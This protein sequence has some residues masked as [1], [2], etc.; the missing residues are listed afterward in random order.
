MSR[1]YSGFVNGQVSDWSLDTSQD[2]SICGWLYIVS[3]SSGG[4]DVFFTVEGS[5]NVSAYQVYIGYGRRSPDTGFAL[6]FRCGDGAET[7][8]L[9]VDAET[10][11][12]YHL[13]LCK[14]SGQVTAYVD[15]VQVAQQPIV[16][17]S[18]HDYAELGD[19]GNNTVELAQVK[20][21]QGHCLSVGELAQE[22]TFWAPQTAPEDVALWLQLEN[23]APT[24]DSSG[25]G[26][27]LSEGG[28]DGLETV[29][30]SLGP[31]TSEGTVT[32]M[33]GST[34][35]LAAA[36]TIN[37]AVAL[38][39]SSQAAFVVHQT[40]TGAVTIGTASAVTAE[41]L[42]KL[43]AIWRADVEGE[44]VRHSAWISNARPN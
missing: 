14:G 12:W 43:P 15:G 37:A 11:Q 23:A 31:A 41:G 32:L 22:M 19:F 18:V 27:V 13:A 25:N 2:F 16:M 9:R 35:Q 39:S 8:N 10:G 30:G 7:I 5:N 20:V 29:P 17:S 33:S 3:G 42:R 26:H 1:R 24:L 4:G 28:S 44:L 36:Q 34:M 40:V 21:W 38:V 6:R